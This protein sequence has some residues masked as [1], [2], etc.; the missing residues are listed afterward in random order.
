MSVEAL[1]VASEESRQQVWDLPLRLCHW[2][3]ALSI[4][5][6][7]FTAELG[8]EWAPWHGRIGGLV[9]GLLVFRIVWGFI[10][11]RHSRFASFLPTPSTVRA[12]VT[13][14]WQGVGHN[15]LGAL[16]VVAMLLAIAVQV[17]TGLFSKDD[18]SFEGP[19][20]AWV[21]K[22]TSDALTGLH[23]QSFDVLL[24]L[25][26][27]HLLAIA[28]YTLVKRANLIAPMLS[29][30]KSAPLTADAGTEVRLRS[31]AL[32]AAIAG[33]VVWAVFS[34]IVEAPAPPAE[35][36]PAAAW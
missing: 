9:L 24:G 3:L 5:A 27:L 29:G 22:S 36:A 17:G 32:A 21:S 14:A 34:D 11:T 23:H 19:L 30:H 10:G 1:N 28:F 7:Y 12:Y 6:A 25:I 8:G 20:A 2:L 4:P 16:A 35:P 31:F 15:P 18:I 33:F 26:V 13:G